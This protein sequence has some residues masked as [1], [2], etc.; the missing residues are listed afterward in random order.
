MANLWRIKLD[1]TTRQNAAFKKFLILGSS[2]CYPM[3]A[4]ELS[5]VPYNKALGAFP[6]NI[7][8]LRY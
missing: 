1:A 4:V 7:I 5:L 8:H 6:I 2:L 3:F